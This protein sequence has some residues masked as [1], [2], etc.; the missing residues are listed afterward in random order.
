MWLHF[1]PSTSNGNFY[2]NAWVLSSTRV[3]ATSNRHFAIGNELAH[4]LAF[5]RL[6]YASYPTDRSL[7]LTNNST[8]W[9][10]L[11]DEEKEDNMEI[12]FGAM[13]RTLRR[14]AGLSQRELARRARL[15]FSYISKVENGRLPPPAADTIV[16]LCSIL[17]VPADD[18]L[19]ATHKLPTDV[20]EKI[21]ASAIAQAFLREAQSLTDDQ[22]QQLTQ[23]LRQLKGEA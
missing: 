4:F 7:E 3:I 1:W 11:I 14:Q 23:A 10:T 17:G 19:A 21:S 5:D 18:L 9:Y 20:E 8:L 13:L 2:K 16:L 6:R 12:T 15:D 22:W